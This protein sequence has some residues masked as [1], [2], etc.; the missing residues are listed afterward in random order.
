MTAVVLTAAATI[1][2]SV[3][4]AVFH[5]TGGEMTRWAV[6]LTALTPGAV[7]F[8]TTP[9]AL[10]AA[11]A[12]AAIALG[13]VAIKRTSWPLALGAGV[14]GGLAVSLSYGVIPLIGLMW[15]AV[16]LRSRRPMLLAGMGAGLLSVIG[17]W[18]I[19][20]FNWFAGFEAVRRQYELD[21]AQQSR[22][23]SYFLIANLVVFAIVV[24]PAIIMSVGAVRR[25]HLL[26]LVIPAVIAVGIANVSGLSKGEVERIWLPFLPWVTVAGCWLLHRLSSRGR[27]V[28]LAAQIG[29]AILLQALLFGP[30]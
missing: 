19:V 12:A 2:L 27:S 17:A 24:G 29:T 14:V 3:G 13:V 8:G 28:A 1:P 6:V 26:W 10:F 22:P 18:A 23:Y 30:W 4:V 16:A 21:L 9:G 11:V 15:L 7:F 20:G 25:D 5:L